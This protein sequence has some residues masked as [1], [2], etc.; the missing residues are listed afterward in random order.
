MT[1]KERNQ[2]HSCHILIIGTSLFI[3][4]ISLALKQLGFKHLTVLTD[5]YAGPV[6]YA[7]NI[8]I[9]FVDSASDESKIDDDEIRGIP[10]IYSFDF[11]YGVGV[12]VFLPDDNRDI[13]NRGKV[14]L[15]AAEYIAGYCAFWNIKGYG[16]LHEA[17]PEIRIDRKNELTGKM[18]AKLCARLAAELAEGREIRHFPRFYMVRNTCELTYDKPL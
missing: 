2:I 6:P 8:I 16:W 17:I 5:K 1:S 7:A 10:L 14:R 11:V 18:A 15:G 9:K 4:E 3:N 13:L 12:I